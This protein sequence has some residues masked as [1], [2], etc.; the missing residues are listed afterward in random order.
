MAEWKLDQEVRWEGLG[1]VVCGTKDITITTF[2][3]DGCGNVSRSGKLTVLREC[4]RDEL[5]FWCSD[6]VAEV[7]GA[8]KDGL[9][10]SDLLSFVKDFYR[11]Y[12][13]ISDV[14]E[15]TEKMVAR[16]KSLIDQRGGL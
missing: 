8:E 5:T 1:F 9:A 7:Q 2:P 10:D 15:E 13:P 3:C 16:A 12:E 6:C 14:N 11:D 4:G